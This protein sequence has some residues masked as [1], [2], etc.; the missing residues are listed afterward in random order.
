MGS[1]RASFIRVKKRMQER[2][3]DRMPLT[4][5]ISVLSFQHL[6]SEHPL[7]VG[8]PPSSIDSKRLLDS[9]SYAIRVP[10]VDVVLW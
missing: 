3:D 8:K 1:D 2:S 5:Q 9:Q 7:S 4:S 10:L 6:I